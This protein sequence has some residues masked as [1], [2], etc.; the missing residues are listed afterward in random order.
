MEAI[1][2]YQKI[3]V[4]KVELHLQSKHLVQSLDTVNTFEI[5]VIFK[6]LM[7]FKELLHGASA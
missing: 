3:I 5:N 4:F 2:I 1:N 6:N 7:I